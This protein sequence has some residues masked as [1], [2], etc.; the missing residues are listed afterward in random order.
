[1]KLCSTSVANSQPYPTLGERPLVII[2]SENELYVMLAE[3]VVKGDFS[4]FSEVA[5][6]CKTLEIPFK[7]EPTLMRIFT[8]IRRISWGF[9]RYLERGTNPR[10]WKELVISHP[11][12]PR[13]GDLKHNISISNLYVAMLDIH[14]YTKFCQESKSNIT[15]LRKLDEFIET[16]IKAIGLRNSTILQREHG[17]EII[18][19]AARATDVLT[20]TFDIL[21]GFSDRPVLEKNPL[22][23]G[24]NSH[25]IVLPEFSVTAGIAGGNTN[26]PLIITESGSIS[27]FVVNMA[28][29][30][31]ARANYVSPKD[32]KIMVSQS[33][34]TNFEQENKHGESHLYSLGVLSFINCGP[35]SF[36]GVKTVVYDIVYNAAE[37]YRV[38]YAPQLEEFHETLATKQWQGKIFTSLI[39]LIKEAAKNR[40]DFNIHFENRPYNKKYLADLCDSARSAFEHHDDF[41]GAVKQLEQ[42]LGIIKRID[43]FDRLL[44]D[45]IELV[46]E[47]YRQIVTTYETVIMAQV[48]KHLDQIFQPDHKILYLNSPKYI[49]VYDRLKSQAM[50]SPVLAHKKRI[51]H[52]VIHANHETLNA[53]LYSGKK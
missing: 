51:W 8:L 5:A 45:L 19:M 24:R 34:L 50:R 32:S 10:M 39:S 14:G 48:A 36:K 15:K 38:N 40:H 30:L 1:M 37:K 16:G 12:Y 9:F 33:V 42:I 27:S 6:F 52:A 22:V 47:A 20:T 13:A 31:Q 35:I 17:D 18:I 23:D 21:D 11:E 2:A 43:R 49:A 4:R 7:V 53:E 3:K 44:I 25:S 29:R 41:P 46:C 28:A 26:L